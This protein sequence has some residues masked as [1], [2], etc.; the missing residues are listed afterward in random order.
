[1]IKRTLPRNKEGYV[2]KGVYCL[3]KEKKRKAAFE[4]LIKAKKKSDVSA[5][6]RSNALKK[7]RGDL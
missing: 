5:E 1:M 2:G 6:Y 4:A 3:P 7:M